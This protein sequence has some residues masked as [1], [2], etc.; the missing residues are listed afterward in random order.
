MAA[1]LGKLT[2]TVKCDGNPSQAFV[3]KM[4]ASVYTWNAHAHGYAVETS[5][6]G[7]DKLVVHVAYDSD[8]VKFPHHLLGGM[9]DEIL[10]WVCPKGHSLSVA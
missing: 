3:R 6:Q 10:G 4:I 5:M 2:I 9:T 1:K 7:S 8:V